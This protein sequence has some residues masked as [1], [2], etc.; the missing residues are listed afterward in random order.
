MIFTFVFVSHFNDASPVQRIDELSS[1]FDGVGFHF[2]GVSETW[3]NSK[4]TNKMMLISGYRMVRVDRAVG[5]RDA[6]VTL[7]IKNDV[8]FKVL[9]KSVA[10]QPVDFIFADLKGFHT[11]VL[12]GVIYCPPGIDSYPYYELVLEELSN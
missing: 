5:R 3:F 4:H 12:V 2:M 1:I 8:S 9:A 11:R 10:G 6:G 7:Y